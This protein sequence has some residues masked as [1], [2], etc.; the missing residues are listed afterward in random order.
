MKNTI[1]IFILLTFAFSFFAK[2]QIVEQ[3]VD[4]DDALMTIIEKNPDASN[5]DVL[6][7]LDMGN[8]GL[9]FTE[10][11]YIKN[12]E[13]KAEAVKQLDET[14]KAVKSSAVQADNQ[15]LS[16]TKNLATSSKKEIIENPTPITDTDNFTVSAITSTYQINS[17]LPDIRSSKDYSVPS[18]LEE[19]KTSANTVNIIK[20]ERNPIGEKV[21]RRQKRIPK[22]KNDR[23][24]KRDIFKCF[25]F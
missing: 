1:L 3:Y 24:G 4:A 13:Q 23:R 18:L 25:K 12:Y 14:Q 2:A 6:N 8:F 10:V 16:P 5:A 20:E 19:N 15:D 11:V 9:G 17:N 22:W 21:K 7:N